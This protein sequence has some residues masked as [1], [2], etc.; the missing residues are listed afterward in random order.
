[1]VPSSDQLSAELYVLSLPTNS[2]LLISLQFTDSSATWRWAFYINL[3]IGALCA[4]V[5]VFLLPNF[6]PRPGVSFRTRLRE[7]D[8]VGSLVIIGAF[9]SGVMAVSFGGIVYPWKSGRIIGLFCTS[10]ILFI[11]FG[12]QQ[13]LPL[14]T[15][16]ARRIF[17]IE[18]L[19]SRTH[20]IL[21]AAIA[22]AGTS[23][24]IPIYYTPLF[25]QFVHNDSALE[26]GVRLLPFVVFLV[27][28]CV[29]NGAIM[30]ATGWYFPWYLGGGVLTVIGG[31]LMYTV[32]ADTSIAKIYGYEIILASGVGSFIQ[33]SF[34]VAQAKVEPHLIPL[35][36][37]YITCGQIGGVTIGLAIANSIFLNQS[38][39]GIAKLLP[40]V[41]SADIQGAISGAGSQFFKQLSP[42]MRRQVLDVIVASMSRTYILVITGGALAVV[43]AL[44]MRREKLF[45]TGGGAA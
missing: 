21:F 23:T 18:F 24:F 45:M 31:A 1:M 13:S 30:S 9:V 8:Y 11:I 4:P 26:A 40:N 42:D 37:G 34:S 28:F 36:I 29:A 43:L 17:P 35:A 38:E 3:C 33:A 39:K 10:G 15:T 25:F 2:P 5:Y 41:P 27:V 44:G 22:A 7:I 32:K 20:L 14:L 12:V 16:T 6:D 19:R